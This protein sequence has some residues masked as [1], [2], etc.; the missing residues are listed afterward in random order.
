MDSETVVERLVAA[1][2]V[3]PKRG[4][5]AP[6]PPRLALTIVTCMDARIVP[7]GAL[8]LDIGDAHV[9]RNAGGRVTD[10]VLRSL[11]VS[12]GVYDV[13]D[14]AVIHH[15]DCG[16]VRPEADIRAAIRGAAESDGPEDLRMITDAPGDLFA[17]VHAVRTCTYL[18][19]GL[20]VW[21]LRYDV[22]TGHLTIEVAA[23]TQG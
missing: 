11:A 22:R 7:L 10:D 3:L 18:P 14:V 17:D 21:G 6:A 8:G 5:M 16:M 19:E 15:T 12:C 4:A 20:R 13:R 1:N 2:Q 23:G 9:L